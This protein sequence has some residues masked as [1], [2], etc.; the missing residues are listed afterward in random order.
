[1]NLWFQMRGDD[2]SRKRRCGAPLISNHKAGGR[3]SWR[4]RTT[5]YP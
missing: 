4:A 3:A 5:A 2:S 1:M